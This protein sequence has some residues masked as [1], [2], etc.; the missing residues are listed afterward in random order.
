M[1]SFVSHTCIHKVPKRFSLFYLTLY[2]CR[3]FSFLCDM[4]NICYVYTQLYNVHNVTYIMCVFTHLFFTFWFQ[5]QKYTVPLLCAFKSLCRRNVFF[6]AN[7]MLFG[8]FVDATE[9]NL[10][11]HCAELMDYF[12]L[13]SVH[14]QAYSRTNK[15]FST[16]HN[17]F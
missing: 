17:H 15:I 4:H 2:C 6:P 8:V 12:P 11:F 14:T 5:Q 3:T 9:E 7:F 13:P 1:F 16:N 10:A